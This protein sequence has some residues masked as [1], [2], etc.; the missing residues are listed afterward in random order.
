MSDRGACFFAL[1]FYRHAVSH[2]QTQAIQLPL[3]MDA[4]T[5]WDS[6]RPNIPADVKV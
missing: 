1:Y 2:P 5:R 6:Q 3:N 4:T